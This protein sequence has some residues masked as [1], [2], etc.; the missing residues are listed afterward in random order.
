ME[1]I[2][3]YHKKKALLEFHKG[4]RKFTT[5]EAVDFLN[6]YPSKYGLGNHRYTQTTYSQLSAILSG[7][8]N[9]KH[10]NLNVGKNVAALWVYI[11]EEE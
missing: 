1:K 10:S 5:Q 8:A 7:D 6:S 2:K 3:H 4:K 11:G 9:Y